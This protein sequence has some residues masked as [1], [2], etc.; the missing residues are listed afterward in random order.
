MGVVVK[1]T[2]GKDFTPAPAGPHQG[3]CCDVIDKGMVTTEY[4]GKKRTS[5]KILLV[6]QI[7][8]INPENGERFAV[9]KRYTA[10]LHEKATLRKDLQSWRGRPFTEQELGGFDLDAVIGVNA[11]LNIVHNSRDGVVYANVEAIMP[12][13]RNVPKMTV[14]RYVRHKDRD[15]SS[16]P[17]PLDDDD[18][19]PF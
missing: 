14:E 15:E 17:Q 1:S 9:A 7:D 19:V 13:A 8:E 10:S 5:H 16:D 2:S 11:M 4:E 3:V 18:S 6:W 12:P